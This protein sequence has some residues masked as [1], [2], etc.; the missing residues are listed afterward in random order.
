MAKVL[1]P[2]DGHAE[3]RSSNALL[4]FLHRMHPRSCF[5]SDCLKTLPFEDEEEDISIQRLPY[6]IKNLTSSEHFGK[7][8]GERRLYALKTLYAFTGRKDLRYVNDFVRK[9]SLFL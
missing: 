1:M 3:P 2:L 7:K 6:L 4:K 9:E 8:E 5:P